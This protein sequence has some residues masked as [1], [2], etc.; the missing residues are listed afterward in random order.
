M[1]QLEIALAAWI[2][3]HAELGVDIEKT[4]LPPADESEIQEVEN[5][6]GF[7]LPDDLRELYLIANGQLNPYDDEAELANRLEVDEPWAPF[8]GSYEFLSLDRAVSEYEFQFDAY[9]SE[10]EFNEKFSKANP[11]RVVNFNTWEVR[12]GDPVDPSGWNPDWFTFGNSNADYY[13][14]DRTPA[15]GGAPGQIVQH[16]AD[17]GRLSVVASSV[18]DLLE[19]ASLRLDPEEKNRYQRTERPGDSRSA[20]YFDMDWRSEPYDEQENEGIEP[21]T[22]PAYKAWLDELTIKQELRDAQF[23]EWLRLQGISEQDIAPVLLQARLLFAYTNDEVHPEHVQRE[24]EAYALARGEQVKPIEPEQ[25]L[26]ASER[27]RW[28]RYYMM[29]AIPGMRGNSGPVGNGSGNIE[30]L[31]PDAITLFHRYQLYTDAWTQRDYDIVESLRVE[32]SKLEIITNGSS[33]MYYTGLEGSVFK[34]CQVKGDPDSYKIEEHCQEIDFA[35][36]R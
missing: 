35:D 25:D 33:G 29:L 12:S 24:M 2:A 20:I 34:F 27:K 9:T 5:R 13:S 4:L 14:I 17:V 18:T 36:Y 3:F 7:K 28:Y 19:Q 16:G 26:A 1:S 22:G 15:K 30:Q 31:P 8:F 21:Q 10:R 32:F 23:T 6:I 11:E